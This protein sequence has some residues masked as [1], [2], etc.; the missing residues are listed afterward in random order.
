MYKR[1]ALGY[2]DKEWA[3]AVS[4]QA[5]TLPHVSNLYYSQPDGDVAKMLCERTGFKKV[6][7]ANSGAEANDCLL[8]TSRCV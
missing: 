4:E 7:F 8:Y 1:Q 6:M 3:K 2:A 5:N